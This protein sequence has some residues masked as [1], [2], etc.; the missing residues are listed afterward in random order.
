MSRSNYATLATGSNATIKSGYGILKSITVS[1]ATQSQVHVVDSV[2]IG[3]NPSLIA[4]VTGDVLWVGP[5]LDAEPRYFGPY[6][7]GFNSGLTIAATSN[8]RVHVEFE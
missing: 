8:A 6:E 2:S 1:P 5:F 4:A 3:T 7:I